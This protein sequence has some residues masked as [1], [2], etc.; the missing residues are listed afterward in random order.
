MDTG[1]AGSIAKVS[2]VFDDDAVAG[3]A[4]VYIAGLVFMLWMMLV[5]IVTMI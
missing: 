5:M 1:S 3:K 2:P 4:D